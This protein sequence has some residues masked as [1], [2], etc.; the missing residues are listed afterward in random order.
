MFPEVIQ[1]T[2]LFCTFY[3]YVIHVYFDVLP[4]LLD[5]NFVHK[6]LVHRPCILQSERHDLVTKEPLARD[7]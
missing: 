7:K 1:V 3:K 5:K 2:T 6:P 4:D